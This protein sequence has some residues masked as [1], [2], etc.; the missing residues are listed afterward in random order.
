MAWNPFWVKVE[1]GGL[2]KVDSFT[3]LN[4]LH[5]VFSGINW[6]EFRFSGKHKAYIPIF[7][8]KHP[9]GIPLIRW[10]KQN[11]MN[12]NCLRRE[13]ENNRSQ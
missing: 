9:E 8:Q 4:T 3:K 12:L 10:A 6:E 13:A 2:V 5:D 11:G 1:S 7:D